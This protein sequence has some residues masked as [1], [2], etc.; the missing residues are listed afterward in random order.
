MENNKLF[1]FKHPI[2]IMDIS[3]FEDIGLTNAEMKVYLALNEL[4]TSTAGPIIEKSGLQNSVVHMTLHR[5]LERGFIS[6]VVQSKTKHYQCT[7]PENIL[8]YLESKKARF[9]N[10]IPELKVRQ[11]P[12]D[13][14]QAQIFIGYKGFQNAYLELLKDAKKGDDYLFFAFY[15]TDKDELKKIYTYFLELYKE[16]VR[17]GIKGKGIIKAGLKHLL[18][19]RDMKEFL[20]A[21]FPVPNNMTICNDKII[22]NAWEDGNITFLIHS[23][24]LAQTYREYFYSIWNK[25]KSNKK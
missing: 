12:F 3:V 22:M 18:T 15:C 8:K 2:I 25:Y 7:D 24:Q 16:R 20:L 4:G 1:I 10:I 11:K 6:Y 5:L 13:K 23:R 19:G 14:Q 21:D 9:E 17:R